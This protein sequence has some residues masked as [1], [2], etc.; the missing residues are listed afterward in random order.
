MHERD[1]APAWPAG[2]VITLVVEV[3][4]E[5]DAGELAAQFYGL[6]EPVTVAGCKV[7]SVSTGDMRETLADLRIRIQHALN[8]LGGR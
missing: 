1:V 5:D 6:R 7:V 8:W 3:Q 2:K 4:N